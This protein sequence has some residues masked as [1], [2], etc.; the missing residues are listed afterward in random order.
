MKH[1]VEQ[2]A[3]YPLCHIQKG[4]PCAH[5]IKKVPDVCARC[6]AHSQKRGF[7][8][9]GFKLAN[10]RTQQ[11]PIKR[12]RTHRTPAQNSVWRSPVE[13]WNAVAIDKFQSGVFFKK[14][15]HAR[16]VREKR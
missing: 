8:Q 12:R 3:R 4:T 1:Q 14:P 2:V 13:V 10:F 16:P 7:M 5:G 9:R 6:N 11:A 15:H